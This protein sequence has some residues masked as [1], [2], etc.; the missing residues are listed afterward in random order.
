MFAPEDS[1]YMYQSRIPFE[2]S[3]IY[4]EVNIKHPD[5]E[6]YPLFG[7]ASPYVVELEPGDILFVPHHWWHYVESLTDSISINTWVEMKKIDD[8]SRLKEILSKSLIQSI[9]ESNFVSLEYWINKL[10]VIKNK[11][12]KKN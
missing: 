12:T 6:K 1:K 8:F 2:E 9:M 3:T 7:K 11:L 10:E 5:L 4:S